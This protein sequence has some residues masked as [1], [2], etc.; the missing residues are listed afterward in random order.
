MGKVGVGQSFMDKVFDAPQQTKLLI[1]IN[2]C[3]SPA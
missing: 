3:A 1:Y 2:N